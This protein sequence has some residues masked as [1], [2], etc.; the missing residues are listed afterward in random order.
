MTYAYMVI[1][2][3]ILEYVNTTIEYSNTFSK[4]T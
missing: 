2:N 4:K 3:I 1:S